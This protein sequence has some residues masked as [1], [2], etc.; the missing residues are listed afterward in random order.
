MNRK[1]AHVHAHTHRI[2]CIESM[3]RGEFDL[4]YAPTKRPGPSHEYEIPFS[5]FLI[6]IYIPSHAGWG[7]TKLNGLKC[8]HTIRNPEYHIF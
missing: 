5:F 2:L 3:K 6:Y 1:S 4:K 7:I 8:M